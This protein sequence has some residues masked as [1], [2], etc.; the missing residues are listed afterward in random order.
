M[1]LIE[2]WKQINDYPGY[3]ISNFGRVKHCNGS[4]ERVLKTSNER[5]SLSK[6]GKQKRV[7]VRRLVIEYFIDTPDGYVA[8]SS[9]LIDCNSSNLRV[10]NIKV[11]FISKAEKAHLD[12]QAYLHWR[13]KI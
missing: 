5:V 10:D 2:I 11:S 1:N 12:N 6:D 13:K 9:N 8:N 7:C 3:Q 4:K